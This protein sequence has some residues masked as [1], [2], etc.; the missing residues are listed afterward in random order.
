MND[1]FEFILLRDL[2]VRVVVVG[3]MLLGAGSAAIGC[4]ALLRKRALVGDAVAHAALPGVALAFMLFGNKDTGVLL[5]GATVTGWFGMIAMDRIVKWT[6]LS[7]DT[8]IGIVLSVLFGL[9]I[10]LLTSIQAGGNAN[11][12]GLDKFL[13][14]QAASMLASD[15]FIFGGICTL[16]IACVI[17]FF[18]EFTLI[19]FDTEFATTVGLPMQ[20]IEFILTTLIVLSVVAGI[21]AVGVVLMAAMLITPG[22][23]AR[24]WTDRIRTMVLL[25]SLFGAMAG[26]GGAYVSYALP[27]MPTGP[28]IVTVATG[29]FAVSLLIAPRRGLLSRLYRRRANRRQTMQENILKAMHRLSERD[30]QR[31]AYRNEHDILAVRRMDPALLRRKLRSLRRDGFIEPGPDGGWRLTE[32]GVVAGERVTRLHRLWEVYLTEYVQIA[33]DHVHD[34]AESIE[35]VLTPELEVELERLLN[36]PVTDPHKQSIPYGT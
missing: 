30:G 34:D 21:Q 33:A 20:L 18:K 6:K 9:G 29:I 28:W 19:S 22:A 26:L 16:L 4:F 27:R 2:N 13:F 32:E 12:S 14:G 36:R 3:S 1:L 24:Y 35:H 15:V 5:L 17:V 23:A 8:T 10:L 31:I 7:E 11:Q 25:S